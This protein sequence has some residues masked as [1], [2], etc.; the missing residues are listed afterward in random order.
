MIFDTRELQHE[1]TSLLEEVGRKRGNDLF[2]IFI[3]GIDT[4][5]VDGRTSVLGWLPEP[6]PKVCLVL[7]CR[8]FII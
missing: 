5:T 6:V 2:V 4:L 1:F 3:D 8:C 7:L